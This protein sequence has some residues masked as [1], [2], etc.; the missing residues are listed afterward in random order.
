MAKA[1]AAHQLIRGIDQQVVNSASRKITRERVSNLDSSALSSA[2][3][4]P[5]SSPLAEKMRQFRADVGLARR[6]GAGAPAGDGRASRGKGQRA[7][8]LL[9]RRLRK[10]HPFDAPDGPQAKQ[11]RRLET[12][13]GP[14]GIDNVHGRGCHVD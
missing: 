4:A 2:P 6:I 1:A 12:V 3:S 5:L 10:L 14:D 11:Q 13:T 9:R 7:S 8:K